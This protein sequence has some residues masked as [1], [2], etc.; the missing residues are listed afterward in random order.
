MP[1][2]EARDL[3]CPGCAKLLAKRLAGGGV[4]VR[5]RG[6]AGVKVWAGEIECSNC[7]QQVSIRLPQAPHEMRVLIGGG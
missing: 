2:N 1:D 5:H 4:E 6:K 7:G 3:R